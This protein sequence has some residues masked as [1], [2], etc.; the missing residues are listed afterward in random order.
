MN[1][2]C[3]LRVSSFS[4]RI[5]ILSILGVMCATHLEAGQRARLSRDLTERLAAGGSDT[6]RVIV[7]GDDEKLQ[8]LAERH[9][10]RIAKRLRGAAVLEL[11]GP[12]L[13]SLSQD[14][15]LPHISG[16]VPVRRLMSVTTEAIGADQVWRGALAG[17]E[18]KTGRGIGVAV[19]DSGIAPH[20]AVK[21]RVVAAVDFTEPNG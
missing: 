6:V 14:P 12:A 9:G 4:F 15:D 3:T 13:E 21:R 17:L 19:I 20:Q 18:G 2:N 7:N 8:A 5:L 10:A 1:Q 11:P 16:D